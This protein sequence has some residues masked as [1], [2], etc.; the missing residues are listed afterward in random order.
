[1][2]ILIVEDDKK[3][4]NFVKRGLEAE[5]FEADT[6]KDGEEGM[7]MALDGS[8]GLLILDVM[9][10]KRDGLSILRELRARK[11]TVPVLTLT[12]KN[13]VEDIVAGLEIGSDD[14]LTKPFAFAELLARVRTLLRRAETERGAE[15]HFAD[16]RLDPVAH[17]VWL[18]DKEMDLTAREYE[19][20]KFFM[21]NP[22]QALTRTIIAENVWTD[23]VF[24]SF[25]NIIDVYIN[26]LRKKLE[27]D[28]GKRLIHTVRGIGY[29]LKEEK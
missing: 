21:C 2:K 4:A 12:A 5:N 7:R 11:V 9:L 28:G 6:A 18:K 13:S 23:Q 15:I 22:N 20:L 26:Y 16:L 14:Y 8:Y 10:P 25:T 29:M 24:D 27:R 17:K 3:I 19:L 1:M